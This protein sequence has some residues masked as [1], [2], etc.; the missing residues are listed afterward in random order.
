L[1]SRLRLVR[2][3]SGPVSLLHIPGRAAFDSPDSRCVHPLLAYADLLAEGHDRAREAAGELHA[4]F[5]MS[6]KEAT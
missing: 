1:W 3:A 6:A 5:L 2:D 4:R